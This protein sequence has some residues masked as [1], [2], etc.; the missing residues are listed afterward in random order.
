[1]QVDQASEIKIINGVVGRND[2]DEDRRYYID[3]NDSELKYP[4]VTTVLG[5][6]HALDYILTPWAAKSSAQFAVDSIGRLVDL[7]IDKGPEVAVKWITGEAARIRDIKREIGSHQ[8]NILEAL[9]LDAPIPDCPEHLIDVE[10]DG[11]RVDQDVISEGLVNFLTDYSPVMEMAEATVANTIHNYAG[12]LDCAGFF[13]SIRIPGRESKGARVAVDLKTGKY[14]GDTARP[15]IVS[16]KSATEVW[17]SGPDLGQKV[18]MPEVDMC[19]VLHVRKTYKGGYKLYLIDPAD[20]ARFFAEFLWT[21]PA[22][23][24]TGRDC[25]SS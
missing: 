10:I 23:V 22:S 7:V 14:M 25:C 18:D 1:M 15:Q 5:A 17:L 8:H 3:P 11:E 24:D 20:E 4:S 2:D 16:Y 6:T 13:P 9:L 19:G 21:V 12:T